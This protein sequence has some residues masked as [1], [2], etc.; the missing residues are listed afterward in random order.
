MLGL[1]LTPEAASAISAMPIGDSTVK[2]HALEVRG[3]GLHRHQRAHCRQPLARK[4]LRPFAG[5]NAL[6]SRFSPGTVIPTAIIRAFTT[7]I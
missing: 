5:S 6:T 1:F 7:C 2:K 3:Q 4:Q